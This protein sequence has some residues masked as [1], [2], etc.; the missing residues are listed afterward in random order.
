VSEAAVTMIGEFL[1]RLRAGDLADPELFDVKAQTFELMAADYD[2][3]GDRDRAA[4][5]RA[6]A[7]QA[8]IKAGE[9]RDA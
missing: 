8:R 3:D 4:A 9:L 1:R 6:A 7:T 2:E 5:C